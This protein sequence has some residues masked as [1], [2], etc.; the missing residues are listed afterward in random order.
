MYKHSPHKVVCLDKHSRLG[1]LP[2]NPLY[3]V[4]M[5]PLLLKTFYQD[6]NK[7]WDTPFAQVKQFIWTSILNYA[8][9]ACQFTLQNIDR[10]HF[11]NDY[12]LQEFYKQW[13]PH[14]ALCSLDKLKIRWCYHLSR[15][16]SIRIAPTYC[17]A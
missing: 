5:G 17:F 12:F 15:S 9:L 1:R 14:F 7:Q 8:K 4:Q 13:G 2:C 3:R 6:F 16:C 11:A 10:V